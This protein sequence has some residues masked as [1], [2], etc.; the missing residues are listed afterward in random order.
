MR[1]G[2]F[3]LSLIAAL[4]IAACTGGAPA[5]EAPATQE[6]LTEADIA[7]TAP[8]SVTI[9]HNQTGELVKGWEAMIADFNK[10]NGKGITVKPEFQGNYTQIYQK[11]LGAIQAGSMPEGVVAVENQVADYAKAGVLVELD[12]YINS[13]TNG[14]GKQALDDIYKPYIDSNKYPQYGNRILSFPFI[15]SLE[16]MFVNE[17]LLKELGFTSQPKTWDDFEKAAK[18]AKKVGPDGKVTRWGWMTY[19]TESFLSGVLTRGGKIL[20]EDGTVGWDGK[21]GVETLKMLQRCIAEEWCYVPKGFDWQDRFGEGNLLF[22]SGTST[23]RPFIRAA[24]KKPISWSVMAF[25]ANPPATSQ[26]IQFGGV[27]AI[28]RST[29]EKQLAVWEFLKWFTDTKQTARWSIV[30]SYMPVRKTALDDAA[31][32]EHW[33]SKDTQGRQAFELVPTSVAG[34]S[35][36]G[37]SEVRDA[38]F[39]AITKVSTKKATPEDALAAAAQKANTIL[40][41]NK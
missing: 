31:L 23:G 15:K 16:V 18:A 26:T 2:P 37:W 19:G 25:P 5:G 11:M 35:I 29:P 40:K 30:S 24:F 9:W 20:K 32:K 36:R 1:R 38:I 22:T 17:D 14:L 39:E 12:Q 7:L 21:E 6:T 28:T 41:E 8:V 3:A 4:L 10:T 13:K 33:T 34:P 27:I